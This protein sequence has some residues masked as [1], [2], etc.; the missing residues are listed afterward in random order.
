MT[1]SQLDQHGIASEDTMPAINE[2]APLVSDCIMTPR[3]LSDTLEAEMSSNDSKK[4][5]VAYFLSSDSSK[6]TASAGA[7]VVRMSRTLSVVPE[8]APDADS[9]APGADSPALPGQAD[10]TE[11][12][13]PAEG[14]AA[15]AAEDSTHAA[16]EVETGEIPTVRTTAETLRP[17]AASKIG[18][19]RTMLAPLGT[20]DA[21]RMS[22][23]KTTSSL[24]KRASSLDKMRLRE[25]QAVEVAANA[26]AG[27]AAGSEAMGSEEEADEAMDDLLGS[28]ESSVICEEGGGTRPW[29]CFSDTVAWASVRMQSVPANHLLAFLVS[30][31]SHMP[32]LG[33]QRHICARLPIAPSTRHLDFRL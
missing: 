8:P 10:D 6:S 21:A 26:Q 29:L 15:P 13:A 20:M 22:L 17:A 33:T 3:K 24:D 25:L 31:G 14:T 16:T 30:N 18:S 11:D 23:K 5:L 7:P 19:S 2:S 32:M 1:H 4:E 9:P 27:S 28:M 12:A